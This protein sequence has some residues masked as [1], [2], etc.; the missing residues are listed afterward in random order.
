[1]AKNQQQQAKAKAQQMLSAGKSEERVTA[2]TGLAPQRVERIASQVSAPAAKAQTPSYTGS[3]AQYAAPEGFG[4]GAFLRAREAGFSD[5][6][7]KSGV[8]ELRKQGMAIGQRVDIALNPQTYGNEMAQR[9]AAQG[10]FSDMGSGQQ[11]GM[12]AVFLPQGSTVGGGKGVVWA[13]GPGT[14]QQIINMLTNQPRETWVGPAS[15]AA[16]DQPYTPP[17]GWSYVNPASTASEQAKQAVAGL[18]IPRLAGTT[19]TTKAAQEAKKTSAVDTKTKTKTQSVLAG[20]RRQEAKPQPSQ[21][22]LE[23]WIEQLGGR[24]KADEDEVD[25]YLPGSLAFQR[26]LAS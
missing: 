5:T 14:D 7:I 15:T 13:A 10:G 6:D 2:K 11:Y 25:F 18:S 24:K 26:S 19:T 12:R 20:A 1:M 3:L 8:E 21:R 9:G 4:A 17:A 23:N 22:L 16:P